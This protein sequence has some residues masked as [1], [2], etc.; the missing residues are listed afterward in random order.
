MKAQIRKSWPK[1]SLV[2]FAI[3]FVLDTF[4]ASNKR[5]TK[6]TKLHFFWSGSNL[7]PVSIYTII[8]K[9]LTSSG[10]LKK[11]PVN[12][13]DEV[14]WRIWRR[15]GDISWLAHS[16]SPPSNILGFC[17]AIVYFCPQQSGCVCASFFL[18]AQSFHMCFDFRGMRK[19]REGL[20]T[21]GFSHMQSKRKERE[22]EE[23][24]A[25]IFFLFLLHV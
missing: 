9:H 13:R 16:L 1:V 5:G 24:L 10:N 15:D 4:F 14:F 20:R 25:A 3:S 6:W 21:A 12:H 22:R 19:G 18:E 17:I 23:M 8:G 7:F 2:K 11:K